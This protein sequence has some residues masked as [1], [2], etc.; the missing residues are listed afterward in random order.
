M[1]PLQ[2]HAAGQRRPP[3]WG[4]EME[5][6]YSFRHWARD[7]M[8]WSILNSDLDARRKCAAVILEL[9]GGAEELVRGLPPQAIM[10]GGVVNGVAVDPMTYVL[11]ALSERFPHLG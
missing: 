7:I 4:P 3:A 5:S 6:R 10:A 8:V 11:H 9:R 1:M 2:Q